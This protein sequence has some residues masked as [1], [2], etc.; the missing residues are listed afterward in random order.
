MSFDDTTTPSNAFSTDA[1][2]PWNSWDTTDTPE[3]PPTFEKESYS[4]P[5]EYHDT[6]NHG[7]GGDVDHRILR[8]L[9]APVTATGTGKVDVYFGELLEVLFRYNFRS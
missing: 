7:G 8:P 2:N 1:T 6:V 5:I 3:S 4:E 9:P